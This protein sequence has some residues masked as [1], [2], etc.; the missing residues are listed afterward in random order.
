[1]TRNNATA[2]L[3]AEVA[4]GIT[5]VGKKDMTVVDAPLFFIGCLRQGEDHNNTAGW[6]G[7]DCTVCIPDFVS[8]QLGLPYIPNRECLEYIHCR[9][10]YVHPK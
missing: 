9:T 8:K 1:M 5:E 4:I 7:G 2:T 6:Q 10:F 3:E